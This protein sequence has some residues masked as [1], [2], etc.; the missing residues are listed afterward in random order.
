M[1]LFV[2]TAAAFGLGLSAAGACDYQKSVEADGVDMTVVA[3]VAVPQSTRA[4][5]KDQDA[6][7]APA[8]EVAD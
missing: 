4:D 7:P 5:V 1:K 2:L 8:V 3:S 6:E